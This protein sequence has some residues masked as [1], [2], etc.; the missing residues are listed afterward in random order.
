MYYSIR[1]ITRF[2]YSAPVN[3]SVMEVR[4]QPRS[5]GHQRC[6]SFRLQTMPRTRAQSYQDALGN[7]IHHFDVPGRHTTLTITAEALVEL[8]PP[9]PLPAALGAE[10]WDAL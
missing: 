10:A 4:M 1:H 8:L 2:R 7:I 3:E 6:V 9:D 5:D